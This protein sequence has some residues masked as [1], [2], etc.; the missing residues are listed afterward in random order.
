[1]SDHIYLFSPSGAVDPQM[2]DQA[3]VNLRALGYRVTVDRSAAKR[4]MRFA[5]TD[6]ERLGAFSRAAASK[7]SIAM[8][9]RGGYGL[10]RVLPQLDFAAL[11][12][13]GK[14]WVGHSDFTAFALALLARAR[15]QSFLGVTGHMFAQLATA[16]EDVALASFRELLD[17]SAEAVGWEAPGSPACSVSG[18]LWG[19]NLSMVCALA[20][21]P[22]LP[23]QRGIFFCEDVA[24]A[25]YRVERLLTQLLLAGVLQRQRAVVL[26]GFTEY[27]LTPHDAGFDMAEVTRWLRAQ[28]KPH[29]VP[30]V[31]GLPFSH[32]HVR[33]TLPVGRKVRLIVEQGSAFFV[34]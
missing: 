24:E 15:G 5:G 25:P 26:G 22:Y 14:R 27:K 18:V 8:V 29:G 12:S 23:R 6:A 3:V 32:D 1:M 7:A 34:Y 13:S 4:V 17:A 28:L 16:E 31:T 21:S 11:A 20:G 2:L 33:L 10:T 30:V 19:G 9:T